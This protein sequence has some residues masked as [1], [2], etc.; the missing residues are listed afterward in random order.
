MLNSAIVYALGVLLMMALVN[1]A[2]SGNRREAKLK[3]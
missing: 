2:S 3:G 1:R